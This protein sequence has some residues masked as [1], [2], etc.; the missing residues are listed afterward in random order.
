MKLMISMMMIESSSIGCLVRHIAHVGVAL[1]PST[2]QSSI[3]ALVL[4]A[5]MERVGAGCP[6]LT[7]LTVVLGLLLLVLLV[8]LLVDGVLLVSSGGEVWQRRIT[9][10][11]VILHHLTKLLHPQI[12]ISTTLQSMLLR[13][14][15]F[16]S[17]TAF[18]KVICSSHQ[19]ML[20]GILDI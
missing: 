17:S 11:S 18:I 2:L 13:H 15:H 6:L 3:G 19:S 16:L 14:H 5:E 12:K 4:E 20:G 1:H 8:L 9:T 10:L 7:R